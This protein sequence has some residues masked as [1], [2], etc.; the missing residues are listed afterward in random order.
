MQ[1]GSDSKHVGSRRTRFDSSTNRRLSASQGPYAAVQESQNRQN[2]SYSKQADAPW[3]Q[4]RFS[5]QVNQS[6]VRGP[7]ES[8]QRGTQGKDRDCVTTVGG[9]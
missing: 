5:P 2:T 4:Q 6:K 7:Q 8:F 1:E 3:V 9:E